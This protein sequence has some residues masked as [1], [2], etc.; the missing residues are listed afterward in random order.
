MKDEPAEII[1]NTPQTEQET[2]GSN[3]AT[4]I[5]YEEVTL[6]IEAAEILERERETA[7]KRP[8]LKIRRV[9]VIAPVR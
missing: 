7:E 5:A 6:T 4:P 2:S 9:A 1:E 8:P 3:A